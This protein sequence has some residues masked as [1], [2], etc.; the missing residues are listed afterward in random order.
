MSYQ[1]PINCLIHVT[2]DKEFQMIR[3]KVG[4]DFILKSSRKVGKYGYGN[5]DGTPVGHSFIADKIPGWYQYVSSDRNLLPGKYI[6]WSVYINNP[7]PAPYGCK[8]SIPFTNP[9]DSPYGRNMI[10]AHFKDVL[11]AYQASFFDHNGWYPTIELRVGGT[12]RYRFE[13]CYVIILCK[14]GIKELEQYPMWEPGKNKIR[15]DEANKVIEIDPIS[16]NIRD[17]I[18]SSHG[19]CCSWE[20]F[21]FAL[22]FDGDEKMTCENRLFSYTQ[23]LNHTC[24]KTKPHPQVRR[25]VCPDL[26]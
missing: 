5:Y 6:W 7:P 10:C 14:S 17:G 19:S 24:L 8:A 12:L 25:F 22:H 11:A 16:V 15:Y 20:H 21:V 1:I 26:L 9:H 2:H 23:L 13:V 3:Q 4:G 18:K